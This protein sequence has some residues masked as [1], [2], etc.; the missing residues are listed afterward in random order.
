MLF[1]KQEIL[2]VIGDDPLKNF[3]GNNYNPSQLTNHNIVIDYLTGATSTLSNTIQDFSVYSLTGLLKLLKNPL[4]PDQGDQLI[5]NVVNHPDFYPYL[6]GQY[7]SHLFWY[8]LSHPSEEHLTYLVAQIKQSGISDDEVLMSLIYQY[9]NAFAEGSIISKSKTQL[10]EYFSATIQKIPATHLGRLYHI[11]NQHHRYWSNTLFGLLKK[12]HPAEANKYLLWGA[13]QTDGLLKKELPALLNDDDAIRFITG[14]LETSIRKKENLPPDFSIAIRLYLADKKRFSALACSMAYEYL[15]HFYTLEPDPWEGSFSTNDDTWPASYMSLSS[16]A[17]LIL[18][19]QDRTKAEGYFGEVLSGKA[20]VTIGTLEVI[21]RHQSSHTVAALRAALAS[22]TG[23]IEYYTRVLDL[24]KQYATAKQHMD[25]AWELTSHKSKPLRNKV[26]AMLAEGDPDAEDKAIQ[27]LNHKNA[28]TRQTAALIL[29]YFPGEKTAAAIMQML[30]TE[31][32]DN[33]RDVLLQSVVESLPASA[34]EDFVETL[35]ASAAGRG[36]LDKPVEAW[37]HEEELPALRYQNGREVPGRVTRFLLYRMSRVKTM[38]SDI[39]ARFVLQLLDKEAAAPFAL[40]LVQLYKNKGAK[41]E[42]KYLMAIAGLLGDDAVVDKIRTTIN[43]WMEENRYKM[44]EYGVGALALQGSDKALRWVEWYSRKYR[45]KKANVGAAAL[46]ALETA[47]EE[48]GISI[49]ELGDRIVPDFGF[50]GLF[51]HFEINGAPYRAFIDS[52]FKIAYFNEDDKKL[53]SLPA[54]AGK[55]LKDEYKDIAKEVRDVVK[56]QS[57]RMEYYLIIQRRWTK[58]QWQQFFL[59][60]PVMFMYATKLLWG[61]YTNDGLLQDTFIVS[62]DTGLLT[63]TEDE[64]E[65]EE[66]AVT[67]MVHPSQ[68]SADALQQWKQVFFDR[69]IETVFA[70]LDRKI[71]DLS[72]LD[73]SGSIIHTYE[74][75]N[76]ATGSIRGVLE[77]YG[78]H[79]GP[80]GD[81]GYLESFNLL[82]FEKKIEAVLEVEGV[83]AGYG[84]GGDEKLGRLYFVNKA[85]APNKWIGYI[86]S[87]DDE[88]LMK[89]KDIPPIFL[90]EA[91]AAVESI[92]KRE[93]QDRR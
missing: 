14:V 35:V 63:A 37:L 39:E 65:I 82:Y 66:S 22:K 43:G 10:L 6:S 75:T 91:I 47:A 46:Q 54:A 11:S 28:E 31:T 18:Y 85:K 49:H 40:H 79:K 21:G 25:A 45:T 58:D 64:Y 41:P 9:D 81:G 36:K 69:A 61:T 86:S 50:E 7:Y 27:L 51:K 72:G 34:D 52:N 48:L 23:G 33:A 70:Q 15:Q 13:R 2:D 3:P 4:N 67:G 16:V 38:Q 44:A 62:D 90:N 24:L 30:N 59:E 17:W 56:S 73:M 77:K 92:K 78:W 19:E 74:G 1:S 5:L 53:K 89:L 42:H 87:D 55:E 20:F 12:Y 26:A 60:N 93:E 57:P 32:N 80:T 68:L 29:G 83:G 88:K 84:W 76:M 71:P 8:F